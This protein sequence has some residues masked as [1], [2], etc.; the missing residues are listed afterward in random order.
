MDVVNPQISLLASLVVFHVLRPRSLGRIGQR[1]CRWTSVDDEVRLRAAVD[2]CWSGRG[3]G[4]G[5]SRRRG[6]GSVEVRERGEGRVWGKVG[7]EDAFDELLVLDRAI[8]F[9]ADH[10]LTRAGHRRLRRRM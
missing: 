9:E 8:R 10:R 4:G 3:G 1:I 7:L 2:V 5:G 6:N